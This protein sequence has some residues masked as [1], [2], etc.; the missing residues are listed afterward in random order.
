MEQH[1]T[2]EVPA[3]AIASLVRWGMYGLKPGGALTYAVEN[4]LI[5]FCSSADQVVLY[6]ARDLMRYV[7]WNLPVQSFGSRDVCMNWSAKINADRSILQG[8]DPFDHLPDEQVSK[9]L[10]VLGEHVVDEI[11][12]L[13]GPETQSRIERLKPPPNSQTQVEPSEC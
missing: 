2:L 9:V 4:D 6:S 10:V 11:L 1:R 3:L 5:G 12:S 8:W 7:F 13:T